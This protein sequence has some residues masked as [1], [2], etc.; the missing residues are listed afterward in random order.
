M[1]VAAADRLQAP[2]GTDPVV[3]RWW[4]WDV[5]SWS[6]VLLLLLQFVL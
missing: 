6:S 5:M 2:C 4:R 3:E 1:R